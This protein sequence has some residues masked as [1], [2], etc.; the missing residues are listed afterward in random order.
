[1]SAL[2]VALLI[3]A[4]ER[5]E[6]DIDITQL[7]FDITLACQNTCS[8]EGRSRTMTNTAHV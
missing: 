5:M 1:M 4:R 8:N 2:D 3:N 7:L 6:Q